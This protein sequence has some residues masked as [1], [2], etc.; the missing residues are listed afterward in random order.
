MP[1]VSTGSRSDRGSSR[2]SRIAVRRSYASPAA[3]PNDFAATPP[4]SLVT[5]DSGIAANLF[6]AITEKQSLPTNRAA[7]PLRSVQR[8]SGTIAFT[9]FRPPI[10]AEVLIRDARLIFIKTRLFA[11][12][13]LNCS[14][15][16]KGNS[17]W[18]DQ[19]W[20]TQEWDIEVENA[21]IYR[22]SKAKDEW[23]VIGEYD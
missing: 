1:D 20:R 6:W 14:G 15:V 18:W 9:Y 3:T 23:F 10:R 8:P 12:H 17:K 4:L 7:E 2:L 11:G 13:V 19:P 22:L 21:G 16:W 5:E